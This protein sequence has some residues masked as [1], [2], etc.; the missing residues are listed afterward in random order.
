MRRRCYTIRIAFI[1]IL[2]DIYKK[3]IM[4]F[5]VPA[6]YVCCYLGGLDIVARAQAHQHH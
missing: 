4:Y 1:D 2:T 6:M 5:T 3:D